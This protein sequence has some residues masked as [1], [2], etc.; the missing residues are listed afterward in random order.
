MKFSSAPAP[1]Y[2]LTEVTVVVGWSHPIMLHTVICSTSMAAG[3]MGRSIP[4]VTAYALAAGVPSGAVGTSPMIQ[5]SVTCVTVV[6]SMPCKPSASRKGLTL[7]AL[8]KRASSAA[9][10][11]IRSA[12][13]GWV[14]TMPT[15]VFEEFR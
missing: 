8:E 1:P 11:R 9:P 12:L 5:G 6:L 10:T 4:D 14:M 7:V 15:P 3:L 2:V 13:E